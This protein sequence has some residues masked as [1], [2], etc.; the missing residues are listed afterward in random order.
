MNQK[1]KSLELFK[2]FLIDEGIRDKYIGYINEHIGLE[3]EEEMQEYMEE[4]EAPQWG[5]LYHLVL[6]GILHLKARIIGVG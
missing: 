6:I 3:S 5:D 2:Q 4:E 1:E